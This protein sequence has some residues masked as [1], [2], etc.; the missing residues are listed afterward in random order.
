MVFA[1]AEAEAALLTVI[2]PLAQW[3]Q[4]Y[5]VVIVLTSLE[6]GCL[7]PKWIEILEDHSVIVARLCS[8]LVVKQRLPSW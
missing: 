8:A 5:A 1:L 4:G 7:N 2:L 6:S 3:S